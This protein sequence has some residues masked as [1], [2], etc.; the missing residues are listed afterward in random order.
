MKK[1]LTIFLVITIVAALAFVFAQNRRF[2]TIGTGGVTG[3]YYPVGGSVARI[4]NGVMNTGLRLTVESTG[5]SVFNIKAMNEGQLDFSVAQ[6]D[7]VY[8]AFNGQ[9]AFEEDGAVDKLRTVM[10]LH[11]EP[12][13]L[14][15]NIDSEVESFRDIQGKQVNV[16]NPGSGMRNTVMAMLDAFEMS[17]DDFEA[18]SV[19]AAEAPDLLRDGRIDCFFYTVGIG[20]AAVQ[21]VATTT[22]VNI[23]PLDDPEL[24]AL[25]EEFP[26]Y[27][28]AT[29]PGETYNGVDDDIT[30]FGVK[31]LF[32]TTTD[33][34]TDVVFKVV[35]GILNNL[36]DFQNTHP[37]LSRLTCE[38]FL[39]GLGAPLHEGARQAYVQ[40]SDCDL[41]ED[42]EELEMEAV[43][44]EPVEEDIEE[45]EMEEAE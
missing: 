38:D 37:A 18:E 13:H 7:V 35:E 30:V 14:V 12:M 41:E 28:F 17:L 27:A 20:G 16:G 45:L 22:D 5:G 40:A 11:P 33:L 2:L 36:E 8:Q 43:E 29:I 4:V 21:D 9:S 44:M 19:K 6:S 24:E 25:V 31:A 39:S 42:I 23:V 1:P 3:V 15:C 32:T 10:G 34:E 26:Y